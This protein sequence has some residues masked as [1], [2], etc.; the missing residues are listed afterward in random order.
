MTS[1][2]PER[3]R[4]WW[5]ILA[6]PRSSNGMCRRR[7]TASSGETAPLRTSWSNFRR[8]TASMMED[9]INTKSKSTR[10]H[11]ERHF[12]AKSA[13]DAKRKEGL[14]V[15]IYIYKCLTACRKRSSFFPCGLCVLCGDLREQ[16][17]LRRIHPSRQ[18]KV[19]LLGHAGQMHLAEEEGTQKT[20]AHGPCKIR[21]VHLRAEH[22]AKMADQ[23]LPLVASGHNAGGDH[24]RQLRAQARMPFCFFVQHQK[25][26]HLAMFARAECHVLFS[27]VSRL[28]A[29]RTEI[30]LTHHR[31]VRQQDP[32]AESGKGAVNHVKIK[33]VLVRTARPRTIGTGRAT[34]FILH[35]TN[36]FFSG[37]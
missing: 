10:R 21:F 13:K 17:A 1:G 16:L 34:A 9:Q 26:N 14:E 18:F 11:R 19:G 28:A 24:A 22:G 31:I 23:E 32:C 20:L 7:A 27:T 4:R 33:L 12:T 3:T 2:M 15:S 30:M 6:K 8:E 5:S 37:V 36:S 25:F 29:E 35:K